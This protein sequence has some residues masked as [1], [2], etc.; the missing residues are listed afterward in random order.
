[1]LWCYMPNRYNRILVLYIQHN[2]V[3]I[4]P[5]YMVCHFG[6]LSRVWGPHWHTGAISVGPT[7][8]IHWFVQYS[9]YNTLL[10]VV[11]FKYY[12]LTMGDW[13][14]S[15][16][17]NSMCIYLVFQF[18]IVLLIFA[19]QSCL[20]VIPVA[21]LGPKYSVLVYSST[22][23]KYSYLCTRVYFWNTRTHRNYGQVLVLVFNV[24]RF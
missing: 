22:C 3:D 7:R 21:D 15:N 6:K 12:M 8:T 4:T 20:S 23:F 9:A 11:L 18:E 2:V 17:Y 10:G 16:F 24:L 5:G 14:M 1:M 13:C 19:A